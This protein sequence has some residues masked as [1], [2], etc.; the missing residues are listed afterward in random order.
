[1]VRFNDVVLMNDCSPWPES[2]AIVAISDMARDGRNGDDD[3]QPP[4]L[5]FDDVEKQRTYEA[6]LKEPAANSRPHIVPV[7]PDCRS[8]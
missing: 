6:W 1:L 8:T 4:W 3:I 5:F 7:R 2:L